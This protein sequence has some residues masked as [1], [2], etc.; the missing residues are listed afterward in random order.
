[1]RRVNDKYYC[2]YCHAEL[3]LSWGKAPKWATEAT[4]QT[5]IL[6]IGKCQKC[7]RIIWNGNCMRVYKDTIKVV[8]A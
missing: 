3:P 2:D 4:G 7:E 5:Q 6:T 1:M 8:G